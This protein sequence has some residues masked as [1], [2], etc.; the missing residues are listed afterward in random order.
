MPKTA[1]STFNGKLLRNLR[2]QRGLTLVDLSKLTGIHSG[3]IGRWERGSSKPSDE[4]LIDVLDA[5][6]CDLYEVIDTSPQDANLATVRLA[7]GFTRA[8]LAEALG[9]SP[10]GWGPIEIGAT[11]LSG[12]RIEQLIDVLELPHKSDKQRD[13]SRHYLT[14]VALRT[15]EEYYS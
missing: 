6:N 11:P 14:R 8:E 15:R 4:G 12:S 5:L 1:I 9:L 2:E 10:T 13:A 7:Q 3:I